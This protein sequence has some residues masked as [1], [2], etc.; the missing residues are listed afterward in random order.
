MREIS[1]GMKATYNAASTIVIPGSGTYGMEA[2]AR[3]FATGKD[4]VVIRNGW[5]SYRWSQ[6]FDAGVPVNSCTVLMVSGSDDGGGRG[7]RRRRTGMRW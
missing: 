3:Q 1:T 4:V 5:F 7:W 6:I 2:V